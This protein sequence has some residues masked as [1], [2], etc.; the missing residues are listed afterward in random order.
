MGIWDSQLQNKTIEGG[1]IDNT[2]IGQTTPTIG[3]FTTINGEYLFLSETTTPT[4]IANNGAVYTK[5]DNKLYFQDGA[6]VEHELGGTSTKFKSYSATTQ[7]LGANP[8]IYVAGYYEASAA[9]ANLTQL[10][11]TVNYGTA[12]KSQAAHAFLVAGGAGSVDA[13]TVSI[14]VSGISITDAGV[15]TLADSETIVTDI[16]TMSANAYYETSKKWLGQ[17][18]YTLTPS[19]ATTYSADFNY[20]FAKYEDCGNRDFTLTD[21]EVVGFAGASDTNVDFILFYHSSTGWTYNAT[22]FIPGGTKIVQMI[23]D[24]STDD[25]LISNEHFAYKRSGLTTSI[26]GSG[27]EG[28]IAKIVTTANNAIEYVD[29]HIGFQL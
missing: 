29:V 11:T 1:T 16:T 27:S 8:D 10:S 5:S 9:D 26:S 6:G 4:P 19:G 12:N 23:T 15:R 21:F 18:T 2:T 7:G 25:Q 28:V 13:G 24:H 22:T 17:I 3:S 20:G 14:V